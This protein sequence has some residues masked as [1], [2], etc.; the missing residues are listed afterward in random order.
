MVL[1]GD[2]N[3]CPTDD[4]V[5]DPVGWRERRA[6]PAGNARARSARLLNLG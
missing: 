5:Y 3:V 6:V 2:Y 1:A 4:D